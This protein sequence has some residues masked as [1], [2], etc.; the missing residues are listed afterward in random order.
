MGREGL[1]LVDGDQRRAVID[2]NELGVLEAIGQA[3]RVL[4]WH[5]LVLAGPHDQNVAREGALPLSPFK[6]L[7]PLRDTAEI[8]VQIVTDLAIA[9]QWLDPAEELIIGNAPLR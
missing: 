1:R 3:L 5:Q 4:G 2:P 9:A 7:R 8:F 6:Q